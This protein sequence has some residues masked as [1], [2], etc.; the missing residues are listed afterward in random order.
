MLRNP[1]PS[2]WIIAHRGASEEEPEN[3][4]RAFARA[5]ELGADL[6]EMDLHLSRDGHLV[7]IHDARV[8]CRTNGT[9]EVVGLT[10]AELRRLDAGKGERI[11]TLEEV[12]ELARGRC[13]L[14]LE[15]KGAGT[16][17]PTLDTIRRHGLGDQV[18]V[19]SF[20]PAL[21]REAGE[22]NP[23]VATSLL[24]G[25]AVDDPVAAARDARAAYVHL[26]WER[27]APDPSA[28]L[29]GALLGRIRAAGLGI[30]LW[31]EERP[32]VIARLRGVPVDGVCGNRPEL[33]RPLKARAW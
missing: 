12:I 31:H 10:L 19:G 6:V 7:V 18:I 8:D 11:P 9:G 13:G 22:R 4:L 32:H 26:C 14:Y 1:G 17:G 28:L 24:V 16:A 33:L 21:V 15:L 20:D 2:P 27:R 5:I 29:T 23:D 25:D 3:T 30:V